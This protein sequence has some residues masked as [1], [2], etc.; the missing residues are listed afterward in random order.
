LKQNTYLSDKIKVKDD[1]LKQQENKEADEDEPEDIVIDAIVD[2]SQKTT[3]GRNK[4]NEG[5]EDNGKE[6]KTEEIIKCNECDYVPK[7][8]K[9]IRSH[10]L[11]AHQGEFQCQRGCKTAFKTVDLL[12]EHIKMKH[13]IPKENHEFKCN[14]CSSIFSSQHYLRIHVAKQHAHVNV[15]KQMRIECELCR[16]FHRAVGIQQQMNQTNQ[17]QNIPS[18]FC[19]FLEDCYRVPNC[20]YVHKISLQYFQQMQL[21]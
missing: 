15:P 2:G 13:S 19:K 6:N 11:L 1:L 9:H 17:S 3:I 18:R 7:I 10:R 5:Q 8:R 16:Y 21:A 20:P 12:D 14:Q 4:S